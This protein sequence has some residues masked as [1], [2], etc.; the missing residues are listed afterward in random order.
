MKREKVKIYK[1]KEGDNLSTISAKFDMNPTE[2]LI[3]NQTSP[4]NFYPGNI[5]YISKD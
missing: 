3:K 4:K 5:L 2:L 1:I